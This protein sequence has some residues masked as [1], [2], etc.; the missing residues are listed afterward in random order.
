[1][2]SVDTALGAFRAVWQ[3]AMGKRDSLRKLDLSADGFWESFW[4]LVV[5]IPPLALGW[6]DYALRTGAETRSERMV[7]FLAAAVSD[8]AVWLI[9]LAGFLYI[10]SRSPIKDRITAYVVA[11]NWAS[12][13]ILWLVWPVS[14]LSL[15]VPSAKEVAD[16]LGFMVFVA[17]LVFSW[18][19]TDAALDK[20]AAVTSAVFFSMFAGSIVVLLA[21]QSILNLT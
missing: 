13:L 15:V 17:S 11:T 3:M 6:A 4:A 2:V 16:S 18:R 1:M 20:G 10:A 9:P 5:S 8:V 14:M 7:T 21:M 19:I 12:A